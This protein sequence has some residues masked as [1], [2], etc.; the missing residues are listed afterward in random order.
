MG[1]HSIDMSVTGYSLHWQKQVGKYGD[2]TRIMAR[3]CSK[4]RAD[5]FNRRGKLCPSLHIHHDYCCHLFCSLS[6]DYKQQMH[7]ST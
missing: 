4:Q 7:I 6:V 5:V 2:E 1:L 3:S